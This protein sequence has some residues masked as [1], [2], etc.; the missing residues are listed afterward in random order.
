MCSQTIKYTHACEWQVLY[1][2]K[3]KS[4]ARILTQIEAHTHTHSQDATYHNTAP[5]LFPGG[6]YELESMLREAE[7]AINAGTSI[8]HSPSGQQ[9]QSQGTKQQRKQANKEL[10]VRVLLMHACVLCFWLE[11]S[12]HTLVL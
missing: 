11:V 9:H 3:K 5:R 12:E 6:D 8:L 10:Q 2:F 4:T 1:R 7:K